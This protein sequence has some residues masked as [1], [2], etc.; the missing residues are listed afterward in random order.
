MDL[1]PFLEDEA[2]TLDQGRALGQA[3]MAYGKS[4]VIYLVGSLGAGKT[5]ISR[6]LL[7]GMGHAGKVR[8][9]TY[10]LMENYDTDGLPVAHL[11]LYRLADPEELEFIG[12]RDMADAAH[13]LLVEW[14][15]KGAGHLP[16]ADLILALEMEKTGR[17]LSIEAATPEGRTAL[18]APATA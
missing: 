1:K 3:C 16:P 15:E 6:G 5:T 2:A 7:R 4:L 17:R 9:P 10:T 12:L 11:D 8:S 14:P 18:Q 13:V